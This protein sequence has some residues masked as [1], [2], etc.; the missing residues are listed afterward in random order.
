[1][2]LTESI[3][4]LN[5]QLVDLFGIHTETGDPMFQIVFS[6]AQFEKRHGEYNDFTPSGI[7]IRTVTE[8]REAPKYQWIKG[9]WVLEQ[10]CVVPEINLPELPASKLSY[11]PLW[12]FE[13]QLGEYLP[14]RIDAAK[15]VIDTMYAAL[16]K[17][18]LA[19]YVDSESETTKEG[20]A[21]MI[22]Q[23][24]QD[25]FGNETSTGD[26]LAYKTGVTVPS[27]YKVN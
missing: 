1:M 10:L 23:L 5:S 8:V 3:D 2:E 12:I 21:H 18:S 16:G 7:F 9:R 11:E 26:A 24:T 25:L 6:D 15:L 17:S 22:D 27:N 14:P 19:N 13:T 4:S 20:R